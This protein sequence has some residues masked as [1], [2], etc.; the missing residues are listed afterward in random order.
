MKA[1]P[2]GTV[3]L[4]LVFLS[5]TGCESSKKS[6]RREAAKQSCPKKCDE[7]KKIGFIATLF[8][9]RTEEEKA[10]DEYDE[11]YQKWWDQLQAWGSGRCPNHPGHVPPPKPEI[12]N[13]KK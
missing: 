13:K 3:L 2:A 12:L 1:K 8:D 6:R 11:A 9:D 5:G 4:L 10:Q 7:D